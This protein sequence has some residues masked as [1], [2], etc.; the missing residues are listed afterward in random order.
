MRFTIISK[1]YNYKRANWEALN[2]DLNCVDW[3]S[4]L[5]GDVHEDWQSFKNI[6]YELMDLHI[7]KVKIGGICQPSWF[8]AE[9]HQLCREK[10][11][12]H[13]KYKSTDDP[14]LRLSRY[15][16][17]STARKKFKDI[18]SKKMD[19][20]FQDDEDSGLISKKFWSYVKA[21]ARNTRIPELVFLDDTFKS[22]PDDQAELFNTSFYKQFS[23]SSN[24]DINADCTN[25]EEFKIDFSR[26]RVK[27]LLCNS[28]AN[29]AM[30][31]DKIN[32]K[33]LKNCSSSLSTPLSIL[34][35]KCYNSSSIPDEWKAA[36][37]VPVHKKGPKANVEN[38]RP[39]SLTCIIMKVMER[40]IRDEIMLKCG[41]LIDARQHGFL[42]GKSCTTQLIDFC[43]SH[44]LLMI[45]FA[46]M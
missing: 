34:F 19:N 31:P 44:Y 7:P 15:L 22:N 8:D 37:V 5:N 9:T 16:K 13:Q 42:K 39:I 27:N 21:T 18:V 20:S 1:V 29:K 33:V 25:N 2:D 43:D 24:Y 11:R 17:F 23:E 6:L 36:L 3:N 12:L 4:K 28:N 40:I 10:E 14:D 35:E 26:S 41:H 30:G 46:Q 38:Y 45:T 32:G